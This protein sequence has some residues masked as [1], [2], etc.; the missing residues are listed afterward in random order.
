M[1][2]VSLFLHQIYLKSGQILTT[3]SHLMYIFNSF[4]SPIFWFV[5]PSPNT[6]MNQPA[7]EDSNTSSGSKRGKEGAKTVTFPP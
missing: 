2:I 3:F 5:H 7:V 6:N 1:E 4:N